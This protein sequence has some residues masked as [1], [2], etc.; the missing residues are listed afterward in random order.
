[1][2]M[3]KRA[4][5]KYGLKGMTLLADREYVGR[6]WF[7]YLANKGLYFVI[8]VKEGIYHEEI[9]AA[10]GRTWQQLKSAAMQKPKGKKA[11][12]RVKIGALDLHYIVL[13]NPRPDADDELVY[14]LTNRNSPTEAARLYQWRWQIEVCF[15]HLKSNGV[16]LE[17]MNVEGKEK[18]HLMMAIAVF[19]YILAIREGLLKECRD[20]IRWTLDKSS[21][22]EYRAVSVFLKGMDIVR[23]KALNLIQFTRYLRGITKG[24]Y[25]LVFQNV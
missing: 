3:L 17:A 10:K 9:N 15:K 12:K 19:V 16:N 7:K 5:S 14:L 11:S 21:G 8:R 24:K 13:R 6:K 2:E 18:R 22:F 4:M 25:L 1:M 20:G 23:R